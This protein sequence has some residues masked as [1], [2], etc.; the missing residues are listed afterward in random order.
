MEGWRWQKSAIAAP[1]TRREA[2]RGMWQS[3]EKISGTATRRQLHR[4]ALCRAFWYHPASRNRSR[5]SPPY[6]PGP[7]T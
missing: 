5:G 6:Q 1:A 3:P 2:A 7:A 4:Y